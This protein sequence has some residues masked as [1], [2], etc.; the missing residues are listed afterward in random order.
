MGKYKPQHSRLLFI[1]KK[2]RDGKYPNC[3]TLAEEW[4]VSAK[5]IQRD[6]DYMKYQL[7]APIEYSAKHRGFRY[8]EEQYSL[9][10]IAIKQS[11]LFGVYL[12][13]KLLIQYE[14][15]PIYNSLCSVFDKIE[16]ALPEKISVDP[17]SDQSK[18][19]VIPPFTTTIDPDVW[20]SVIDSLRTSQQIEIHYKT[21]GNQPNLRVLDPYHAVR[22]EGDW[23]IVGL[24]HLRND[25]R[26][27]SMSRILSTKMTGAR[28]QIPATFSFKKL[29]GSHFGVHWAHGDIVVKIRFTQRIADYVRERVWHPSQVISECDDGNVLLSLTVNHLLELKRWILSWGKE[30]VVLEPEQLRMDIEGEIFSMSKV[31]NNTVLEKSH[32]YHP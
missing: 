20:N 31:Y 22:F 4:E 17:I 18:F 5:T 24:C 3:S 10:A 28:F 13:Q 8:T 30:A 15:T 19:T 12:A 27:F 2:I 6:L 16:Q 23:Y 26:T 32:P 21:P 7:D 9:P 25:I 1:D 14:G 29:S 11:D